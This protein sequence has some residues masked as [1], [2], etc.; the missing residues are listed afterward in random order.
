MI[1]DPEPPTPGPI[2]WRA[3]RVLLFLGAVLAVVCLLV[4]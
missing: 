3:V 1:N 2:D 4:N